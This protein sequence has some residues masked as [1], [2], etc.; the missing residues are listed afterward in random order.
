MNHGV[1]GKVGERKMQEI[2][3]LSPYRMLIA[4]H[5]NKESTLPAKIVLG[6]VL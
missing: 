2:W 4:S 5:K 6:L 3:K 1:I